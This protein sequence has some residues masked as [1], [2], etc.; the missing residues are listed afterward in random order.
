MLSRPDLALAQVAART[1]RIRRVPAVSAL[2]LR[3]PIRVAEQWA[4]L[5][6]LSGG[7]VDFAAGRGYEGCAYVPFGAPFDGNQLLLEDDMEV[8][9]GYVRAL[10]R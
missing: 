2:P 3:H 5:D 6:L 10:H 4:M 7:P 9:G 8:G 1:R